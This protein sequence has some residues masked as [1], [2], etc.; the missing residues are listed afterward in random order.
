M[1]CSKRGR[2]AVVFSSHLADVVAAIASPRAFSL[3]GLSSEPRLYP[4][5]SLSVYRH[6]S[7]ESFYLFVMSSS[8]TMTSDTA[9]GKG[10]A[11]PS[12]EDAIS[13]CTF[14]PPHIHID[15]GVSFVSN[16]EPCQCS[17]CMREARQQ[18]ASEASWSSASSSTAASPYSPSALSSST[19][20]STPP[21]TPESLTNPFRSTSSPPSDRGSPFVGI[22]SH[23][24]QYTSQTPSSFQ[25]AYTA[26]PTYHNYSPQVA[27]SSASARINAFQSSTHASTIH[28]QLALGKRHRE[29]DDGS[30][31]SSAAKRF[32]Y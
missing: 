15:T 27:G 29:D 26:V 19:V 16:R 13:T 24:P 22:S 3:I 18:A 6:L 7:F 30:Q 5:A 31:E 12:T 11:L 25:P 23:P 28:S 21:L 20:V 32:H 9:K 1:N 8:T 4:A 17:M 2:D 10:R 14:P